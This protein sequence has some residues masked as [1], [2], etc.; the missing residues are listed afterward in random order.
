MSRKPPRAPS[1]LSKPT[2]MKVTG[3]PAARPT[4][5]WISRFYRVEQMSAHVRAQQTDTH[6]LST[7]LAGDLRVLA[8]VEGLKSEGCSGEIRLE[9]L[10]ES[11]QV[12]LSTFH[13][14]EH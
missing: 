12:Q 7:G 4:V 13:V 3:T 9:C 6:R 5:Y 14:L 11:L 8:V 2:E 1:L 10:Q